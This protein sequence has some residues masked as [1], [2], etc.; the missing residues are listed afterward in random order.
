MKKSNAFDRLINR[1]GQFLAEIWEAPN[2][3]FNAGESQ[4]LGA[5]T[6]IILI[7]QG[8]GGWLMMAAICITGII[9]IAKFW[10]VIFGKL[11]WM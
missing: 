8:L 5:I 4:Q 2:A 1:I 7:F 3:A 6:R 11:G 9:L 10:F